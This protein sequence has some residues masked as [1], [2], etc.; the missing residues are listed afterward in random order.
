MNMGRHGPW[1]DNGIAALD[2][3]RLAVDGEELAM[4]EADQ[5]QAESREN[6][7]VKGRHCDTENRQELM[8]AV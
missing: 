8:D 7:R 5:G 2:G 1:A 3:Q 6:G 4:S